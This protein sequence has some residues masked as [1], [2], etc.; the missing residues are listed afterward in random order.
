MAY[1]MVYKF[2]EV[3]TACERI[4][5]DPATIELGV[6][7]APPDESKLAEL[8]DKGV[9]RAVFG[10]PQGPRDEVLAALEAMAPLVEAMRTA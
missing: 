7:G 2:S 6:F 4:G 5:R 9:R 1:A 3:V 10:L 8:A